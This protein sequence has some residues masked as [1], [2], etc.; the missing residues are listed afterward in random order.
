M[1]LWLPDIIIDCV[2]QNPITTSCQLQPVLGKKQQWETIPLSSATVIQ[3]VLNIPQTSQL[4]IYHICHL[5]YNTT[6]LIILPCIMYVTSSHSA[7]SASASSPLWTLLVSFS[8]NICLFCALFYCIFIIL[9]S[10][11][12]SYPSRRQLTCTLYT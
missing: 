7:A 12:A 11:R 4:I 8:Q 5:L 9:F 3:H 10:C 1:I 6:S 2:T